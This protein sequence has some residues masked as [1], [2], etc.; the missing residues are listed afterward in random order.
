[1]SSTTTGSSSTTN[2]VPQL[3]R[4]S[5]IALSLQFEVSEPR[6]S[7][8]HPSSPEVMQAPYG[9]L[10]ID[11]KSAPPE[12][13]ELGVAINGGEIHI[14]KAQWKRAMVA[15]AAA[16]ALVLVVG[17]TATATGPPGVQPA[18]VTATLL[19]GQSMTVAK[20]VHTST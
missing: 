2:T 18:T 10:R 7:T 1:M 13:P 15:L 8:D 16:A 19:P 9:G 12:P 17:Q 3:P 20:T 5:Y 11:L 14:M 4:V 6:R